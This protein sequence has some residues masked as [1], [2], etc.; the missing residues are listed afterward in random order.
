MGLEQQRH[1]VD[2]GTSTSA[3]IEG[4]AQNSDIDASM[5]EIGD[6]TLD[7]KMLTVPSATI[8]CTTIN[9]PVSSRT[10][11]Q[12]PTNER[13]RP[14]RVTDR[15][16][17]YKDS[18]FE[19]QFQPTLRRRNCRKIQK[20]NPAGRDIVNVR[21]CQDLGRGENKKNVTPTGNED[22]M[23]IA[24]PKIAKTTGQKKHFRHPR[25]I[26]NFH[27]NRTEELLAD[28]QSLKNNQ[29]GK[30][31]KARSVTMSYPPTNTK[32]AETS[33]KTLS[34]TQKRLRD[35]HLRSK[36]T[37]RPRASTDYRPAALRGHGANK[38]LSSDPPAA[39]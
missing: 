27:L 24:S 17:R 6:T 21:E 30:E 14:T 37:P 39:R 20:R 13:Q 34:T 9:D 29:R 38:I 3:S 2:S 31:G 8:D 22:A 33:T 26:T 36:S 18:A 11:F 1:A 12:S 28:P 19:T 15:P 35:A 32:E 25:F 5:S 7:E 4:D 23:P 16:S 10:T